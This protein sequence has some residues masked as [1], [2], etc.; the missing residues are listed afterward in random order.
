[1]SFNILNEL[2]VIEL[3]ILYLYQNQKQTRISIS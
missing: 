1:M 2:D 3:K